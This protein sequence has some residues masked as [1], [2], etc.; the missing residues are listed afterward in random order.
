MRIKPLLSLLILNTLH[1]LAKSI[2]FGFIYVISALFTYYELELLNAYLQW[3]TIN[4]ISMVWNWKA[5]NLLEYRLNLL[6]FRIFE[7]I[8]KLIK[9]IFSQL[10]NTITLYKI[11]VHK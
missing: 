7:N 8:Q 3:N 5:L 6:N 4:P 9:L 1:T 11:I 10:C 2:Q